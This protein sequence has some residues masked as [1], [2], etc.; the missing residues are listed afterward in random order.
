MIELISLTLSEVIDVFILVSII[1]VAIAAI[2]V[3]I[4][5]YID[6]YKGRSIEGSFIDSFLGDYRSRVIIVMYVMVV[7][8]FII[9]SI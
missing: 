6:V 7:I 3:L 2:T 4:M 5:Y 8:L 1:A 9:K